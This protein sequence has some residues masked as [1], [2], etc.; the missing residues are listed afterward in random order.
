MSNDIKFNQN[1]NKKK[2]YIS[3]G[4]LI[5]IIIIFIYTSLNY[6]NKN[7]LYNGKIADNIFVHG[8]EISQM[9]KKEAIDT[10]NKKY[11][12]Q[13]L[14]LS[15]KND[16]YVI[17]FDDIELKYNTKELVEQAYNSTRTGSYF[18]DIISYISKKIE[19]EKYTIK[20]TYNKEKLDKSIEKIA[21]DINQDAR[22]ATVS[23][24]RGINITPSKSGLKFEMKENKK[25]IEEA[26]NDKKYETIYL[27]VSVTKPRISTEDV[28]GINTN[29][30]S[31]STT[32]N[33]ALVERSYN[34]GLSARRCSNVILKPGETFSYNEHTGM[35]VLSNGYLNAP[36][37][38]GNNYEDAPGGGVCQT[39]TTLFNAA[40]L[41]GLEINQVRNHSKTSQYIPRGRDAMVND[42][43]SDLKF[44]NNFEHSVYIQCYRSGNS[45]VAAIYGSLQDKVGVNIRVDNFIYNGLPGA[46]TYRT[47]TK[48]SKSK[49]SHIYTS[50][51]KQ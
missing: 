45:V 12:P 21:N 19:G 24:G 10:I 40:L 31:F 42:G 32:F 18:N 8:I 22:D 9:S 13:N 44:T 48:N 30:A 15:Y 6:F 50:V 4:L 26:L 29:L 36:V 37:I 17:N 14:N 33:S 47:I 7:Y 20:S 11:K 34:I 23:I 38:V 5:G 43:G 27:K 25:L 41:S 49:T 51:Y 3:I 16:N 46:K 39:S 28:S 35:R 2:I 1:K